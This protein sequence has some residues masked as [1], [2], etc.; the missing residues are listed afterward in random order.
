MDLHSVQYAHAK[1]THT[2][3]VLSTKK[4]NRDIKESLVKET[5]V[6]KDG[7]PHPSAVYPRAVLDSSHPCALRKRVVTIFCSGG[8]I[9]FREVS[10]ISKTN[11]QTKTKTYT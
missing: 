9:L 10:L 1:M 2:L 6:C 7:S 4:P 8:R 3:T 5:Q 11:K